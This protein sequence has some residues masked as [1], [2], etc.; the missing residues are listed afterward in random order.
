MTYEAEKDS[1]AARLRQ[2]MAVVIPCYNPGDRVLPVIESVRT[3][4]DTVIVVDDG[5]TDGLADKLSGQAVRVITFEKN[6][7]KGHS[8]LAGFQEAL[9][10]EH[11]HCIA[12]LDSDGQHD[13]ADLPA[14]YEAFCGNGADLIIGARSFDSTRIPWRSRFGNRLTAL[15]SRVFL[16]RHITDTQS[17]YR[18]HSRRLAEAVLE[19]VPGGR[20]ETELA[21]LALAVRGGF[22]AH[23]APIRTIYEEGNQSSHFKVFRD[24]FRIYRKLLAILLRQRRTGSKG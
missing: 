24:S 6:R 19:A 11:I 3:C 18:L 17:G 22:V 20:Y 23:S 9:A 16:G 15:L 1:S 14:L 12:T 21:I 8:L 2:Q 10:C 13:P 5:S 7:G 4:V